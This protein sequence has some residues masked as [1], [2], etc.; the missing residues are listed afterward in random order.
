MEFNKKIPIF[1][2]HPLQKESQKTLVQSHL[3]RVLL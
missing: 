2:A 1:A 3:K